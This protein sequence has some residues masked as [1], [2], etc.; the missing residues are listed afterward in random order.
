MLHA[1]QI[2]SLFSCEIVVNKSFVDTGPADMIHGSPGAA[3]FSEFFD[4]RFHDSGNSDLCFIAFFI[5]PLLL[6]I[7]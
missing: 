2:K 5:V 7:D 3:V 1:C 4:C 6:L